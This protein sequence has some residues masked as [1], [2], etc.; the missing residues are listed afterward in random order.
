MLELS[1]KNST[2]HGFHSVNVIFLYPLYGGVRDI[3][4]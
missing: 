3:S 1:L 2:L 4:E